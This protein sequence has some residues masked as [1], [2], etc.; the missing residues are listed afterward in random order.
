[1]HPENHTQP[2]QL[3]GFKQGPRDMS[4]MEPS[5]NPT[6]RGG[7][8]WLYGF[9][10]GALIGAN[11]MASTLAYL[12]FMYGPGVKSTKND[13]VLPY[14]INSHDPDESYTSVPGMAVTTH[15]NLHSVNPRSTDGCRHAY[16][17][18][19]RHHLCYN[20]FLIDSSN[21]CYRCDSPNYFIDR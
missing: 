18:E 5:S 21:A 14:T 16:C 9:L 15:E 20:S 3:S 6:L 7:S 10:S 2:N 8:S 19:P 1:M 12:F 17:K 13:S 11:V 4:M